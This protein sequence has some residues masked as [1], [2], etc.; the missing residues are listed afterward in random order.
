M[1]LFD[2]PVWEALSP[3]RPLRFW[4]LIEISQ[5]GAQPLTVSPL[6]I[7]ERILNFIKGL[8][9]LDDRLAPFLIP[10]DLSPEEVVLSASQRSIAATVVQKLKQLAGTGISPIVQLTGADSLSKQFV[11]QE[12]ASTLDLHLRRLPAELLPAQVSELEVLARFWQREC[13]LLPIALYIDAH[14]LEGSVQGDETRPANASPLRRF[15]ARSQGL[16]FVGTREIGPGFGPRATA[17]HVDKPGP[18]E[19]RAAWEEALQNQAPESPA[20]LA[21]QFN[22]NITTIRQVAREARAETNGSS[23]PIHR[24]VWQACLIHTSPRLELLA[25]RLEP[26]TSWDDIVLPEETIQ[27][28]RQIANQVAQRSRVYDEWGFRQKMSRG[29]GINALFAGDSGTGKTMATEVLA[30]HLSLSLYRIDLSAVVSKY[31]GETEK[32]LR[33]LFDAAE[34][35]GAILFF[36]EADALFG[37]RSEVKDSHDRYANI[38]INYLLQRMESYR[39]LAILATNMKEA[40]IAL[41]CAV[42]ASSSTSPFLGLKSGMPSG[43]GFSLS[44]LPGRI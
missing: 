8:N 38:E 25:Q 2:E 9:Y 13:S 39:G 34:D 19:Q 29:L 37:K 23:Q 16:F 3:E 7:D 14:D 17:V 20:L 32:N 5:P 40:L 28:L 36:D 22:L 27:L 4:R 30:N 10:F 1:A 11:A 35:G 41:S 6:R 26:K 24:R 15:L 12:I 18:A 31:I 43:K 33:R 21:S 42:C 44:K